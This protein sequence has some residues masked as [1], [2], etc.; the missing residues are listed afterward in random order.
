M[1]KV[2]ENTTKLKQVF[3]GVG[4]VSAEIVLVIIG[5]RR[6]KCG[7]GERCSS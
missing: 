5:I 4:A 6:T 1:Q 3:G 7:Q 2:N